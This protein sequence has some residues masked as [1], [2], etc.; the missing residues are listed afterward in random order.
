MPK[1]YDCDISGSCYKIRLFMSILGVAYDAVPVDFVKKEH[2]SARYLALN[3]F[4]EIPIF[5]DGDLRLR[6]AQAILVYLARKYDKSDTWFP[7]DAAAQGKIAQ[8]LSTGGGEVMNAAGARL[9][10]VLNYPLDLAKLHAGA[11]R[12]FKIMDDHLADREFLEL[13]HATIGDIACMPYTALAGEGG[14]D[15][16]PYR[17][18][19]SWIE[20]I[21][22][23]PGFIP[24]PGIATAS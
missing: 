6:D 5:E 24:M 1:L 11:N 20:R 3:P 23:L 14:I 9:V 17:N 8:W 10:K 16:A 19:L 13:G 7:N 21:K 12:V 18:V 2:K 22:R 15:L 4:G